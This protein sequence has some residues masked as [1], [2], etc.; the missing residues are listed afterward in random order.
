M[1]SVATATN[2]LCIP[3]KT[4]QPQGVSAG[5]TAEALREHHRYLEQI[6]ESVRKEPELKGHFAHRRITSETDK[7]SGVSYLGVYGNHKT[8]LAW[9]GF[10]FFPART[11]M[12][13]QLV[14]EGSFRI[15]KKAKGVFPLSDSTPTETWIYCEEELTAE[16]STEAFIRSWFVDNCKKFLRCA[17]LLDER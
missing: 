15:P 16:R 5:M 8:A 2:D 11:T 14:R 6:I 12:Y 3:M 10:A 9:F 13:V 4:S 7:D 1:A 17:A